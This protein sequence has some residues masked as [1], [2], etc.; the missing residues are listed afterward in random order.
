MHWL[1]IYEMIACLKFDFIARNVEIISQNKLR[2]MLGWHHEMK[3]YY[4]CEHTIFITK[5]SLLESDQVWDRAGIELA[6]TSG[7]L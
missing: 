5:S 1:I 7:M 4:T 6:T 3:C 2:C